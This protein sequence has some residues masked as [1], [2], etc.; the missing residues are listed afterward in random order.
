M[1]N[2]ILT[3]R[4]AL[5]NIAGQLE[6]TAMI[7]VMTNKDILSYYIDGYDS[8][9]IVEECSSSQTLV[10]GDSEELEQLTRSLSRNI[11]MTVKID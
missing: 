3:S 6:D 11:I 2:Q 10:T 7:S 9:S 5:N 1:N 4:D 8:I